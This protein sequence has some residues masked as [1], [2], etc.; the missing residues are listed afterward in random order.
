MLYQPSGS[1]IHEALLAENKAEDSRFKPHW[2]Q[3]LDRLQQMSVDEFRLKQAKSLRLLRDDGATYNIYQ[4]NSKFASTW[5]LDLIPHLISS[6]EWGRIESGL[7]ERAELFNCI[8]N[9]IYGP[10]ELIRQGVIPPEAIF[11]HQGF[12][13]ACDGLSLPGEAQLILH[14]VDLIRSDEGGLQVLADRTQAPSG[15]GYALENRTVMSRV[16]PSLYRDSQVHRLASFFQRLRQ[17]LQGLS[18]SYQQA[19]IVVLT[20]GSKNEAYFEHAFIANYLGFHLVQ[21]GDL[22]VRN[23]YLWMKSLDG[24]HRVDVILR[25]VDDWYCDPLELRGN[26][27]LG[28]PGLL[29]VVRAG[30]VHIANPLGSGILENPILLKYLPQISEFYL[31]RELR[32]PSV[33]TYW[34]QDPDDL[35]YIE[36]N[37]QQLIIK[38]IYRG[39]GEFT[40]VVAQLSADQQNQ[41]LHQIRQAPINYVAQP[42]V[43]ASQLPI[44][45]KRQ[46]ISR[47]MI[48]RGF[49]AA[50][51][52]GY[53]AMT[54]GLTRVANSEQ[55]FISSQLGSISKDTWVISSEP[56]QELSLAD[57][58]VEE[59]EADLISLPSRVVENLFWLGRHA[60]RAEA[61]LRLLR[62]VFVLLSGEEPL[63]AS[64]RKQLL[65]ALTY[66]SDTFPGFVIDEPAELLADPYPELL[67]IILDK[68][69]IG[70]VSANLHAMFLA[71]DQS[72]E[73]ISSDMLQVINEIRDILQSLE[74]SLTRELNSAPEQVL[75]PLVSALMAL[76]G[77]SQESMLRGVG[78][79]FMQIGKRL[80]RALQTQNL[81][82]H[83]LAHQQTAADQKVLISATLSCMENLISY[84]RRYRG[85]FGLSSCFDLILLDTSNPRSLLF[86]LDELVTH[87]EA[88]PQGEVHHHE[89]PLEQQLARQARQLIQLSQLKTLCQL[90]DGTRPQ[91]FNN[92]DQL[93]QLLNDLSNSISDK[94]FDLRQNARQLIEA[95]WEN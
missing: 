49:V 33:A 62:T 79:R 55:S 14:G 4:Q 36:A 67:S 80:E 20:P 52:T 6:E 37:F 45:D 54:G 82:T 31:G 89:L 69:R 58:Q 32:L 81:V 3:Y 42:T 1:G 7:I 61:S 18:Q 29:S 84:R 90:S 10:R 39:R 88:L 63:S 17:K 85:S 9:D 60:E 41:L 71:A 2:Q 26:S 48:L 15:A 68:Q 70:S 64:C 72:K 57:E 65:Q 38:P 86:Q 34:P 24:L 75:D 53:H 77:L 83:M 47:P 23:G 43:S 66:L 93:Q 95:R 11:A 76:S 28:V 27:L 21:S 46:I 22:V 30:R 59:Q 56:G 16:F 12:L 87:I 51:E 78:W 92:L 25:R 94:Y 73:M 74:S 13:R 40:Q 91:L 44:F 8:L 5:A 35:R 50:G 19:R